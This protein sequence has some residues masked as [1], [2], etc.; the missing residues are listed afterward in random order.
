[1]R[2][3]QPMA[4]PDFSVSSNTSAIAALTIGAPIS[5]SASSMVKSQRRE[6]LGKRSYRGWDGRLFDAG[7]HA[8][9]GQFSALQASS[10]S[11]PSLR[12]YEGSLDLRLS[13]PGSEAT[14]DGANSFNH[15]LASGSGPGSRAKQVDSSD[16]PPTRRL[17]KML[18]P[19]QMNNRV[20]IGLTPKRVDA[21]YAK[22]RKKLKRIYGGMRQIISHARKNFEDAVANGDRATAAVWLEKANSDFAARQGMKARLSDDKVSPE[23]A[24]KVAEAEFDELSGKA[25]AE[26][27]E[28]F[29]AAD[30]RTSTSSRPTSRTLPLL[31]RFPL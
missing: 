12:P 17:R 16:S 7:Q 18:R 13:L 22:D 31:H 11:G 2:N 28:A 14:L 29:A 19:N 20:L 9:S 30:K 23:A 6:T 4:A 26:L 5:L 1:M 15:A 10:S 3:A 27:E 24:E 21:L 8:L 25:A